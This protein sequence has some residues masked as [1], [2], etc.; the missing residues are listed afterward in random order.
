MIQERKGL[1]EIVRYRLKFTGIVQGVGF[2]FTAVHAADLNRLTKM[3]G[4][5]K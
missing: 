3:A 5:K 2:H 1:K 4:I